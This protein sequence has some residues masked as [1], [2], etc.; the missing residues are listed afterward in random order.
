MKD[1]EIDTLT[2]KNK[3]LN[4]TIENQLREIQSFEAREQD[5]KKQIENIQKQLEDEISRVDAPSAQVIPIKEE[6]PVV[7]LETPKAGVIDFNAMIQQN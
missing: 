3:N 6:R 1:L 2:E 4:E 5:W 7:K